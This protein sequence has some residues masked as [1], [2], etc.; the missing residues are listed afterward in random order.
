VVVGVINGLGGVRLGEGLGSR[1]AVDVVVSAAV[2]SEVR[3]LVDDGAG[4]RVSASPIVIKDEHGII[5]G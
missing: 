1:L 4:A 5:G 3:V 2:D